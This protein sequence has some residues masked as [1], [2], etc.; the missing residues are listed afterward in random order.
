MPDQSIEPSPG[1]AAPSLRLV[2]PSLGVFLA[3]STFSDFMSGLYRL[4]LPWWL[5]DV[6]HSAPAMGLLTM[7]QYLAGLMAPWAGDILDRWDARRIVQVSGLVQILAIVLVVVFAHRGLTLPFIDALGLILGS[8]ALITQ[9]AANKLIQMHVPGPARLALNGL[10]GTLATFSW[11]VSPGLAGVFIVTVG[12]RWTLILNGA[13]FLGVV[14]PAFFLPTPVLHPVDGP[15]DQD[16]APGPIDRF[17][18]GFRAWRH[19]AGVVSLTLVIAVWYLTWGGA[20]T[21]VTYHFRHFFHWSSTEVGLITM[22]AGAIPVGLGLIGPR[23][24]HFFG[25]PRMIS[26]ALVLSGFG[27][28]GLALAKTPW[29]ALVALGCMDG[30]IAPTT[31]IL[32][33]ITQQRIIPHVYGRVNALQTILLTAGQ[34][35]AAVAQGLM[36]GALGTPMTFLL[37]SGST[38]VLGLSVWA[39]QVRSAVLP[40]STG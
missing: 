27:M 23:L 17:M 21:M 3:G 39:T 36:A 18:V 11:N 1:S 24:T 16:T 26:G 37:W 4:A 22:V 31:M 6:T 38:V 5:Y 40:P 15:A 10:L 19:D 33:T 28:A 12:V 13:G 20:Y 8:G 30:A 32:D 29:E 25:V 2:P 34:P 9:L 7:M 35:V 14:V